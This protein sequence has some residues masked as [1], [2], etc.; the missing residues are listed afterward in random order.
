MSQRQEII[1][2]T[3]AKYKRLNKELNTMC[4]KA[5]DSWLNK[6]CQETENCKNCNKPN[7]TY[8]CIKELCN[9]KNMYNIRMPKSKR[10]HY[11]HG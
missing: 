4:K 6:Q 8:K 7:Q 9:K 3:S 1:L 10:W 5:K 2:R 11:Y